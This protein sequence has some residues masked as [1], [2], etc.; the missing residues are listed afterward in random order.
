[1]KKV[2]LSGLLALGLVTTGCYKK[3]YDEAILTINQLEQKITNLEVNL[4]AT[5]MES[6]ERAVQLANLEDII[7]ELD[8]VIVNLE[9]VN[10]DQVE[11]ILNLEAQV[12]QLN[13][14][15]LNL[16]DEREDQIRQ[17]SGAFGEEKAALESSIASLT[18][19][20]EELE[21]REPEV[22]I[23]YIT[24]VERVTEF[25]NGDAALIQSLRNQIAELQAQLAAMTGDDTP[26][27]PQPQS[28]TPSDTTDM[29]GTATDTMNMDNGN[30]P[31]LVVFVGNNLRV[32]HDPAS[33]T[34]SVQGIDGHDDYVAFQSGNAQ[35]SFA[36][37]ELAIDAIRL[38][39][40]QPNYNTQL[41]N[42]RALDGVTID[43]RLDAYIDG[44]RYPI[45][46]TGYDE[47]FIATW[48]VNDVA[49]NDLV[50]LLQPLVPVAWTSLF[51]QDAI[52]YMSANGFDTSNH[53]Y[54]TVEHTANNITITA[55]DDGTFGVAN[56][57][58]DVDYGERTTWGGAAAV[59]MNPPAQTGYASFNGSTLSWSGLDGDTVHVEFFRGT[60]PRG[61]GGTFA[62]DGSAP[63]ESGDVAVDANKVVVTG[64][65]GSFTYYFIQ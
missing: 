44:V 52:E 19:Q 39:Y 47:N 32:V 6:E 18:V 16:I 60:N 38:F 48:R 12:V 23:E 31:E 61:G 59:A 26:A 30:M 25:V 63:F 57:E 11:E 62:N 4:Q 40:G 41:A 36:T 33:G 5:I 13:E 10:A 34:Y 42:A 3:D 56:S 65:N 45:T 43:E 29:S 64:T 2:I 1:M 55:F 53:E 14:D 21:A 51:S 17:L 58:G 49:G 54:G 15:I 20:I 37:Q 7:I 28:G 46:F 35:T 27:D 50:A 22:I 24:V 9:G 8:G